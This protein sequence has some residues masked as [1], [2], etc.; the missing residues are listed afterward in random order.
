MIR[1]PP[2]STLFPYT[3]LFRS[4][5]EKPSGVGQRS[6]LVVLVL[7]CAKGQLALLLRLQLAELLD[8]LG[9]VAGHELHPRLA[10]GEDA[11]GQARAR[12]VR[13]E[14]LLDGAEALDEV[15][16]VRGAQL[17]VGLGVE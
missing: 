17:H 13:D 3:T 16:E 6:A 14:R 15:R 5:A 9:G 2:R 12:V 1:R 7:L 11:L 4:R 8:D 10:L